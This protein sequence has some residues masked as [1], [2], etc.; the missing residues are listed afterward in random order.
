MPQLVP[1]DV[2]SEAANRGGMAVHFAFAHPRLRRQSRQQRDRRLAHGSV[3]VEQVVERASL[4]AR[5]G[6]VELFVE[7]G[8]RERL[9]SGDAES[10]V[11]IDTLVVREVSDDFLQRPLARRVSQ[12]GDSRL[13]Q[14]LEQLQSRPLLRGQSLDRIV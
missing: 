14:R 7:A 10:A 12:T 8:Q 11:R 9:D 2:E 6:Y 5:R 3:L 1:G 13:G 4:E